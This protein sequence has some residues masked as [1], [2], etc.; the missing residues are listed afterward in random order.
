MKSLLIFSFIFI[1]IL[2]SMAVAEAAPSPAAPHSPQLTSQSLSMS[3]LLNE[4]GGSQVTLWSWDQTVYGPV[5][6]NVVPG[7]A[8][9]G[10]ITVLQNNT[11]PYPNPGPY[12]ALA[13][14]S[15]VLAF[16]GTY[17]PVANLTSSTGSLVKSW[18]YP[19][20]IANGLGISILNFNDGQSLY[21]QTLTVSLVNITARP[22]VWWTEFT[23]HFTEQTR[24]VVQ[25]VN[26]YHNTTVT[27]DVP[28]IPG[29][30]WVLVAI[31]TSTVIGLGV[32]GHEEETKVTRMKRRGL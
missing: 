12:Y 9:T 20:A 25:D 26:V 15:D 27:K 10:G 31:L 22:Y 2:S 30:V 21:N 8:D 5:S 4:S 17:E 11:G 3:L 29:W 24:T 28:Y 32:Q 7:V 14:S 6:Y 13:Y 16:T 1:L 23:V 18:G 19:L